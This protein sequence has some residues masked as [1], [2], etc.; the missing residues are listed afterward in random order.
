MY[1]A[2]HCGLTN[3]MIEN[4]DSYPSKEEMIREL[5]EKRLGYDFINDKPYDWEK[6]ARKKDKTKGIEKY[7]LADHLSKNMG[8]ITQI[9]SL[10]ET[11]MLFYSAP[12]TDWSVSGKQAGGDWTCLDCEN[13]YDPMQYSLEDRYTCPNCGSHNIKSTRSGLLFEVERLLVDYQKRNCLPKFLVLENVKNL[14]SKKFIDSFNNWV[15]R[16]ETFNYNTYWAVLNSKDTGV[17]QNRERVFC[18]SIRKDIDNGRFEFPVPFDLGIRLKDILE[19]DINVISKYFLSDE[20]QARLKITDPEFKKNVIGTTIGDECTRFG[21]R[22]AVYHEDCIMGALCASD[23]KQPKQIYVGE[24]SIIGTT[25]PEGRTIGQRDRVYNPNSYVAALESTDYKQPKQVF[26]GENRIDKVGKIEIEGWGHAD[27]DVVTD[28]GVCH[29]LQTH[30]R[31]NVI[32]TDNK[33]I[34]SGTLMGKYEKMHD[35]SRRVYDEEGI[36]PT[37]HCLNGGNQECKIS[38]NKLKVV[39]KLTPKETFMLQDF[40]DKDC[41]ACQSIGMSDTLAYKVTGNSITVRVIEL[42][43][44]HLYKALYN[45]NYKCFDEKVIEMQKEFETAPCYV[46]RVG[47]VSTGKSQGGTVY[48]INGVSQTITAGTHGYGMGNI[49]DD[50][51]V[52]GFEKDDFANFMNPP[53]E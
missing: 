12:C 31:H 30:N 25:A 27:T 29:T 13:K 44:Q 33:P 24:K 15:A 6:A 50:R 51:D 19:D 3:E 2:I 36:A 11:D 52:Y 22:D 38:R 41:D 42:I 10:P 7:W 34:Q 8:D 20:V 49:Y 26:V 17:P 53:T 21:E 39:R 35:I 47:N 43:L 18:V 37:L 4:Y 32:Q 28:Q 48:D 5:T 16:L 1:A 46:N 23:Y 40:D 45:E 14:V 9:K